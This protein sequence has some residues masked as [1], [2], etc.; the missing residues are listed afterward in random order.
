MKP[1]RDLVLRASAGY[2]EALGRLAD[3]RAR[4]TMKMEAVTKRTRMAMRGGR[5]V[6]NASVTAMT[7]RGKRVWMA[8]ASSPFKQRGLASAAARTGS[9][10]L[11]RRD[12]NEKSQMA[13]QRNTVGTKH[14]RGSKTGDGEKRTGKRKTARGG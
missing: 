8:L 12:G 7:P 6:G 9:E 14:T 1:K 10:C 3:V 4:Q 2:D 11:S 13:T 5:I